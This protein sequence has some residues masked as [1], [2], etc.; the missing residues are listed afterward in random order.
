MTIE[1]TIFTAL[2]SLANSRVYPL[3]APEKVAMPYIVYTK[4]AS[5]PENTLDGGATIDLVR[6]QIDIY[7]SNYS[8]AK[9]LAD[10]VRLELEGLSIKATMQSEFDFFETDLHIYRVSQ[11]YLIWKRSS[12]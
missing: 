2:S 5:V 9:S 12:L 1:Q 10:S 8:L 6:M 3:I 7:E 4:V 11:D